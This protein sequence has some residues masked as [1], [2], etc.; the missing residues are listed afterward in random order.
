MPK[1]SSFSALVMS[2]IFDGACRK[3]GIKRV[4]YKKRELSFRVKAMGLKGVPVTGIGRK[5]ILK[6]VDELV[7]VWHKENS[8]SVVLM[9][10]SKKGIQIKDQKGNELFSYKIYNVANCAIDEG[11][12]DVFLFVGKQADNTTNCHAF[13]CSDEFQA[14]EM[15]SAMSNAFH[16]AFEAWMERNAKQLD[17]PVE[18]K[19]C[20]QNGDVFLS[21]DENDSQRSINT[22]G[23]KFASRQRSLERRNSEH[24]RSSSIRSEG[25]TFSFGSQADEAFSALLSMAE[26]EEE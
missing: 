18:P 5:D 26:E 2:R 15:C 3:L 12:A 1:P 9:V 14:E 20:E 6:A 24:S 19:C 21:N 13:Y 4:K 10:S 23:K 8:V 16:T 25:S 22:D 17:N 7:K 11:N